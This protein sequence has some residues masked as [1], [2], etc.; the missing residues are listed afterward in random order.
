MEML[1]LIRKENSSMIKEAIDRV[2]ELRDPN[3]MNVGEEVWVKGNYQKALPDMPVRLRLNSLT[4][5]V[6]YVTENVDKHKYEELMVHVVTYNIVT[7]ISALEDIHRRR[8]RYIKS[9]YFPPAMFES[10]DN[11]VNIEDF[12]VWLMTD[13][14]NNEDRQAILRL[15]G[16]ITDQKVAT[17][18]DD[19]IS[20]GVSTRVGIS[21]VETAMVPNPVQLV[22]FRTFTEVE[23]PRSNFVLRMRSGVREDS[24]PTVALFEADGGEWKTQA[25]R[26]IKSWLDSE[27]P[28]GVVVLA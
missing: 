23:Q 5:L 25:M 2:L 20:Q 22:P 4:G 13:F 3:Q 11:Y 9:E 18:T 26:N 17:A 8:E 28:Q 1:T 19:G 10:F 16:N 6:E 27:L 21:K 12:M 14:Q 15:V 7:V 24:L